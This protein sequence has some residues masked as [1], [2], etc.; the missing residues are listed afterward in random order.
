M[1]TPLLTLT[2]RGL[3]CEAGGFYI[4]PHRAVDKAL[5]THGHADHATRGH[6]RYLAAT[7]AVPVIRHR[8][9]AIDI[10]GMAFGERRRIGA[11]DV[12]FHPAGHVPGSAQIRLEHRGQVWVVTG[13]YKTERDGLC[14]D[15]APVACHSFITEC[16]FGLPVYRWRPQSEVMDNIRHWWA[17]NAAQ[18]VASVI[19]AYSFGKAQRLLSAL[20]GGDGPVLVH[21]VIAATNAVLRAQGLALP[22]AATLT[23]DTDRALL[24]QALVIAPPG[25]KTDDLLARVPHETAFASGWMQISRRSGGQRGFVL[26]DHADWPGLQDAI[27]A[28]GAERVYCT[29]G[30][31][32]VLARWLRENGQWA[33]PLSALRA[34]GD[35]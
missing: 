7:P 29:H 21:P 19:G 10:D 9:G 8:L 22:G 24:G 4:D 28:T 23:P 17:G 11:V 18:G 32:A 35:A 20:G 6:G 30:Y 33:A 34:S 27:A 12:A 3:Y 5:V 2:G 25:A 14:E 1:A 16:T 15:F 26:S 31:D 13:D